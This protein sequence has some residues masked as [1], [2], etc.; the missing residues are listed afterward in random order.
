MSIKA[1]LLGLFFKAKKKPQ[2]QPAST[3]D[4]KFAR[5]GFIKVVIESFEK[6]KDKDFIFTGYRITDT[7]YTRF[8]ITRPNGT[9]VKQAKKYV[10]NG[11]RNTKGRRKK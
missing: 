5:K 9:N 7:E 10:E 4:G 6:P 1:F 11:Y 3:F 2:K 8:T